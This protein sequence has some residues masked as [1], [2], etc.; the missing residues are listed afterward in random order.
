MPS[1]PPATTATTTTTTT[2]TRAPITTIA[3]TTTRTTV[4][5]ATLMPGSRGPQLRTTR[6]KR[7]TLRLFLLAVVSVVPFLGQL[8]TSTTTTATATATT[9]TSTATTTATTT[10]L[11]ASSGSCFL[12]AFLRRIL[13]N[14][15]RGRPQQLHQQQLQQHR[16]R[17][18][19]QQQ[20]EAAAASAADVVTAI[21]AGELVL[22]DVSAEW[23]GPCKV[24]AKELRL[25]EEEFAGRVK[26][27]TLDIDRNEAFAK[28]MKVRALPAL[29]L[30]KGSPNLPVRRFEGLVRREVLSVALQ[31]VLDLQGA[32]AN[33][34]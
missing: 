17:Q 8:T 34:G 29:L 30:F 14:S 2:T 27:F 13:F 11:P 3:A 28:I 12:G 20:P 21:R 5:S 18:Q 23:C 10:A 6:P 19:Q 24:M 7:G 26:V 33:P 31:E 9:T 4:A 1:M 16:K 22:V 32:A 15:F 25:V